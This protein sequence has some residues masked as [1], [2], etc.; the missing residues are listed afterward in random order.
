MDFN[1]FKMPD[2]YSLRHKTPFQQVKAIVD[3]VNCYERVLH[4]EL[5]KVAKI[6]AEI[7]MILVSDEYAEKVLNE[8]KGKVEDVED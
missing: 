1:W 7:A 2:E 6:K 5:K 3:A 4:K 8:L